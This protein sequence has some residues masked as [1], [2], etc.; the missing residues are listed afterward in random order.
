MKL[1]ALVLIAV[2]VA[3]LTAWWQVETRLQKAR[4]FHARLSEEAATH[5]ESAE[6]HRQQPTPLQPPDPFTIHW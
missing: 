1:Q 5:A 2:T 4:D 6:P 3:C